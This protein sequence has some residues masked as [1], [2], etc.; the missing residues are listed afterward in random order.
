MYHREFIARWASR[1]ATIIGGDSVD[2][3]M[4]S[5][6]PYMRWFR[7]ITV[8]QVEQIVQ[9]D[10]GFHGAGSTVEL[11]VHILNMDIL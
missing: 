9:A 3:P 11:L 1:R 7:Q 10:T 2:L 4:K 6:D 8:L 5:S